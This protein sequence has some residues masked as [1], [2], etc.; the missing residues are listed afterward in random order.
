MLKKNQRLSFLPQM[1]SFS[2][3]GCEITF[4]TPP[5]DDDNRIRL[6]ITERTPANTDIQVFSAQCKLDNARSPLKFYVEGKDEKYFSFHNNVLRNRYLITASPGYNFSVIVVAVETDFTINP[7]YKYVTTEITV[8]SGKPL[9]LDLLPEELRVEIFRGVPPGSVVWSV[10]RPNLTVAIPTVNTYSDNF[11]VTRNQLSIVTSRPL[12]ALPPK[13]KLPISLISNDP[14][15]LPMK[16][17]LRAELQPI[18]GT[19]K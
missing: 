4:L 18:S 13:V 3:T 14:S 2:L 12:S 5:V 11:E 6:N 7:R 15:F 17:F 9:E 10:S 16:T 1:L 8:V 19:L